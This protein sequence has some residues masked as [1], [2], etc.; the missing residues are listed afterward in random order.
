V[1][2][3]SIGAVE[4]IEAVQTHLAKIR[5]EATALEGLSYAHY[6]C[7]QLMLAVLQAIADGRAEDPAEMARIVVEIKQI[8][9]FCEYP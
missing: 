3:D 4:T 1:D 8:E 2:L 9:M 6:H 7:D 5:H